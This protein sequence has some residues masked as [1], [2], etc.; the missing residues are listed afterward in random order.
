MNDLIENLRQEADYLRAI[1]PNGTNAGAD[2]MDEAADKL[3]EQDVEIGAQDNRL[4]ANLRTIDKLKEELHEVKVGR[5]N[6]YDRLR[7][8]QKEKDTF[9]KENYELTVIQYDLQERNDNQAKTIDNYRNG[10]ELAKVRQE[11]DKFK[12]MNARLKGE[13]SKLELIYSCAIDQRAADWRRIKELET[14]IEKQTIEW[15]IAW[16]KNRALTKEICELKKV[17]QKLAKQIP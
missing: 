11:R 10:A 12:E 17:I 15:G 8:L 4:K 6:C 13:I 16:D 14:K 9:A 7:R 5:G 1:S 2:L 3:Q